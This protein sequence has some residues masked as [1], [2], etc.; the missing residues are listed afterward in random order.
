[1]IED[2]TINF[3][4]VNY[5]DYLNPKLEFQFEKDKGIKMVAKEDI[6]LGELILV[7]KAL[8]CKEN[9]KEK[10]RIGVINL[11]KLKNYDPSE[12]IDLF[13]ELAQKVTKYPLDNEKF[14]Y[15]YDGNNLN[16][17]I[18][19]RKKYLENQINGKIL[20]NNEKVNNVIDNNTY[21]IGRNFGFFN[22]VS[23][24]IW[25]YASLINNDCLPNTMYLGIGDFFILFSTEEIRK[26][27]E[28]TCNYDNFSLTFKDRQKELLNSWGFKCKC[29][30]C[31]YQEKNNYSDYDNFI[32]LFYPNANVNISPEIIGA[33]EKFL[34]ENEKNYSS[35]DLANAYL[36]LEN[37]SSQSKDLSITQKYSDLVT[38]YTEEKHYLF[39]LTNIYNIFLCYLGSKSQKECFDSMKNI[40]DFISKNSPFTTE[41]IHC[42]II[43]NIQ[44]C[45]KK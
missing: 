11:K 18:N 8:A 20:I 12:E 33:F 35:Y 1:M 38:K 40:A 5:G 3:Y 31:E 21:Q 34:K 25:G 23:F 39:K 2:E 32:K 19:Q 15:L 6:N 4:L 27:E 24:G 28:I 16:E 41:E 37:L 43:D 10:G 42:F 13:M 26:G 17:D 44:K 7:E 22:S 9:R 14:Y 45:T 29:K 36:Q 30:L